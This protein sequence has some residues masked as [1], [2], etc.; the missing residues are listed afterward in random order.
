MGRRWD[1]R[2]GC[3]VNSA[4]THDTGLLLLVKDQIAKAE[5]S[6]EI[7]VGDLEARQQEDGQVVIIDHRP[8]AQQILDEQMA[9]LASDKFDRDIGLNRT[10]DPTRMNRADRR[11]MERGRRR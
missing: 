3:S 6:G 10:G 9:R 8:A 5:A 4:S 2:A 7:N 1:E 11:R